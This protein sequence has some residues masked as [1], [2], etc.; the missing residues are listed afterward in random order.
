MIKPF[1]KGVLYYVPGVR[2]VLQRVTTGGSNSARY[3]YSVWLRHLVYLY[4]N[5]MTKIPDVVAEIGPGDSLGIG[6]CSLLSGANVY[7]AFDIIKYSNLEDNKDILKEL[8][9]LFRNK[10]DIPNNGEFPEL[11]PFISD[12]TFPDYIFTSKDLEY[13]LSDKRIE[14]IQEAL[15]G[16]KNDNGVIIK[17]IVP[18]QEKDVELKESVDLIISQAVME[19]IDDIENAYTKM[20]NFLKP[21]GYISH[22]IDFKAH[23]THSLWN[24]HLSYS[25]KTWKIILNGRL[26]SINRKLLSEHLSILMK[27]GLDA[28]EVIRDIRDDGL[29]KNKLDIRFR[30]INKEDYETASAFVVS[31]KSGEE[32]MK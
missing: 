5:G 16:F 8:V 14:K 31:G 6:L 9:S 23:E 11:K 10:E 2:K 22:E 15:G 18:W 19:H 20:F 24:G 30:E 25:E 12:Y 27:N 17:Y 28:I 26:Y 4:K 32:V 3:C 29:P 1:V 21:G 13:L 7:Y